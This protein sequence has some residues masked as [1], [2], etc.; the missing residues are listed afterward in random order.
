MRVQPAA[1]RLIERL[2][3]N[4]GYGG[5]WFEH[6]PCYLIVFALTDPRL[7]PK[8]IDG[9][10]E[11]LRPH[12]AFARSQFSQAERD[13][14]GH[15][16]MAAL[17]ARKITFMFS[18]QVRPERFWIGVKSEADAALARTLIPERYRAITLIAPGGYSEPVPER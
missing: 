17:S 4:P 3:P 8:V 12:V 5:A 18:P 16:I 14:A 2:R 7:E 15:Q 11:H 9:A 10:P 13:A 1:E 6:S